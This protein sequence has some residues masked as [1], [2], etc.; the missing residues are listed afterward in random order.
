M[1]CEKC[2]TEFEGRDCPNC[3]ALAIFVKEEEYQERKQEWEEENAPKEESA[4]KFALP[5]IH[6]NPVVLR[7]CVVT[8]VA[9]CVLVAVI[10]G[11]GSL[12]RG[13]L[14]QEQYVLLMDNGTIMNADSRGFEVF[15]LEKTAFSADGNYAYPMKFLPDGIRGEVLTSCVSPSGEYASVVSMEVSKD[16]DTAVYS[17]YAVK[18]EANAVPELVK[19]GNSEIRIVEV[20]NSGTVYYEEAEI[21]AYEVV[22]TTSL[23]RYADGK[24]RIIAEDIQRFVSCEKEDEFIYYDRNM[25]AYRYSEGTVTTLNEGK[26]GYEYILTSQGDIYYLTPDGNLY[27]EGKKGS[28]DQNV[29]TGTLRAVANSSKVSYVKNG[30]LY[31]YEDGMKAPVELIS[32]Y[33]SYESTVKILERYGKLYYSYEGILYEKNSSGKELSQ[34]EGIQNVYFQKR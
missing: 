33:D 3:G 20:S 10:A 34:K 24:S 18:N 4:K 26:Y 23:Y 14:R 6:V 27:R 12:I 2:G 32:G 17:L 7:R 1:I 11:A 30:S 31:C 16:A 22:L 29:T 28:L 21:G 15:S 5:K 8:V 19:T 9:L 25:Q 13:F